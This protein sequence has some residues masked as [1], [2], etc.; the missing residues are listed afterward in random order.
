MN[1]DFQLINLFWALLFTIP[2]PLAFLFV[3]KKILPDMPPKVSRVFT[4]LVWLI[5]SFS[6]YNNI[7][8][9]G[10]RN[11]LDAQNSPQ[12]VPERKEL[13]DSGSFT[14]TPKGDFERFKERLGEEPVK[15]P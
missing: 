10:P 1:V 12:Y 14:P 4:T 6:V 5:V 9:Y 8:T 13:E 3:L 2:L 7:N 11:K 15:M